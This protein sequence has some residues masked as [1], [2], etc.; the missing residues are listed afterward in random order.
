MIR[1]FKSI[2]FEMSRNK[3]GKEDSASILSKDNLR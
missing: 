3:C 2:P 1:Y